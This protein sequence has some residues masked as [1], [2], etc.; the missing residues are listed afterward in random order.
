MFEFF[1]LWYHIISEF[2]FNFKIFVAL[3]QLYFQKIKAFQEK[4]TGEINRTKRILK[5]AI[6]KPYKLH[7]VTRN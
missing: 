2:F 4:H 7:N 1:S 6:Q 3:L 5:S